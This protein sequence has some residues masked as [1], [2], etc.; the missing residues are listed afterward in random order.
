MSSFNCF[1]N[2]SIQSPLDVCDFALILVFCQLQNN[3]NLTSRLLDSIYSQL[4]LLRATAWSKVPSSGKTVG[5]HDGSNLHMKSVEKVL[6]FCVNCV[7]AVVERAWNS[8]PE[9]RGPEY[10]VPK[11]RP[12]CLEQRAVWQSQGPKRRWSRQRFV[13]FQHLDKPHVL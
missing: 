9:Q 6:K 10:L 1:R 3:W 13:A 5:G 12:R 11:K 4:R 7:Q 2:Y 8:S